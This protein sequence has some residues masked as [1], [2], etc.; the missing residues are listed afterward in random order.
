MNS[1]DRP[2]DVHFEFPNEPGASRGAREAMTPMFSDP[3]DP[4]AEDVGLT[5][6]ELV[7]NVVRHTADGGLLEAWDPKPDVP[8]RVEVSDSDVSSPEINK[9]PGLDGGYGLRIVER[10]ADEWGVV[11]ATSGKTVWAEFDRT[12]RGG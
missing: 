3:A 1:N 9:E 12:K 5:V 8:L 2:A 11:R 7:T 4:I 6:S 10:L